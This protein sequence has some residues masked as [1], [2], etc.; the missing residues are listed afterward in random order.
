MDD[1]ID[2]IHVRFHIH[3]VD[4]HIGHVLSCLGLFALLQSTCL[5]I[6]LVVRV[7]GGT[8]QKLPLMLSLPPL[9]PPHAPSP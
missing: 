4:F 1:E 3:Y 7:M 8:E 2:I 9:T 5:G 6:R